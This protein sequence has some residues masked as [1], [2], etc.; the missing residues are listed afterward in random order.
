MLTAEGGQKG[1]VFASNPNNT[2]NRFDR[3]A[4][5]AREHDGSQTLATQCTQKPE[6]STQ[7]GKLAESNSIK[8]TSFTA[9]STAFHK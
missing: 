1:G 2:V 7:I 9:F 4:M 6:G 5:T 8:G 3:A